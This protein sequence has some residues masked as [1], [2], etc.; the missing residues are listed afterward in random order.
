MMNP[1]LTPDIQAGLLAQAQE[2]GLSLEA[3]PTSAPGTCPRGI[4]A[5]SDA[6][7]NRR[8][9]HPRIAQ[10][11]NARFAMR[12]TLAWRKRARFRWQLWAKSFSR[13]RRVAGFKSS[14]P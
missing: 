1:D 2:S 4:P 11:R 14:G 8:A 9:A 10:G 7:T 3:Y 12:A 13:L 6:V 5:G